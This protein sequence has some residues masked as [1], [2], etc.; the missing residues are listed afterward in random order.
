MPQRF[1]V[2]LTFNVYVHGLEQLTFLRDH[3]AA[4]N[5]RA[6]LAT[7]GH[8]GEA[9]GTGR[10]QPQSTVAPE[11]LTTGAQFVTSERMKLLKSWGLFFSD[12]APSL[13]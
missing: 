11:A 10:P 1:R 8:T 7:S 12:T 2:F 13:A 9:S 6:V 4:D 5:R 3:C